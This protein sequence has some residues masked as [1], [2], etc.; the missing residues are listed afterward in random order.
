[1]TVLIQKWL[2]KTTKQLVVNHEK[3]SCW[4]K[5]NALTED[6]TNGTDYYLALQISLCNPAYLMTVWI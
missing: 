6:K 1:M 4:K 2:K 5:K 3:R